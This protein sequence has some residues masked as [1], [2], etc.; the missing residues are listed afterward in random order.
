MEKV[1]LDISGL[2]SVVSS[3]DVKYILNIIDDH[4]RM[5][6]TYLLKKKSEA[7]N[8]FH[9]WKPLIEHKSGHR[10]KCIWTDNGGEFYF[11]VR[12]HFWINKTSFW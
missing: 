3:E 8:A 2:A 6:W 11:Y 5:T 9:E 10:L 1:H 4:T 7:E 12:N